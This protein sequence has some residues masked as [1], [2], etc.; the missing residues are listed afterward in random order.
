MF[1]FN[2]AIK[3]HLDDGMSSGDE[4][5][6]MF[7]KKLKELEMLNQLHHGAGANGSG[8]GH[9]TGSKH[10]GIHNLPAP[11]KTSV[12]LSIARKSMMDKKSDTTSQTGGAGFAA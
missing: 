9:E 8:A 1:A 3:L 10:G 7:N 4:K 2:M 6:D 11:T 12:K 5:K